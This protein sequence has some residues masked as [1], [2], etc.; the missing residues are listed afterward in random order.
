MRTDSHLVGNPCGTSYKL[1][2]I[3]ILP[4]DRKRRKRAL[5]KGASGVFK[6]GQLSVIMGSSGAGKSTLLNAVSGYR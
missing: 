2:L 6:R 5:L 3:N 4:Q 1:T